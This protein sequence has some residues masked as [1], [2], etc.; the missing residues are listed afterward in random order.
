MSDTGERQ[1]G[2]LKVVIYRGTWIATE[3]CIV[4]APEVFELDDDQIRPTCITPLQ[5]AA[6]HCR[7][8]AALLG[9]AGKVPRAG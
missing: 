3:N 6:Y 7:L 5:R 1:F 4:V 8:T 9:V 2:D